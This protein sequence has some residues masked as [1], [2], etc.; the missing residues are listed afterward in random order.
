MN[1]PRFIQIHSL[2]SYPAV[3]LNRDDSG[4]AKQMKFGGANRTRISSQSIKHSH[5][6]A[7]DRYA[8]HNIP[9]AEAAI[10]S[11]H[12]VDRQVML[13][14][15]ELEGVSQEV[16]D[17]VA[18][19]F[20]AG[21]YGDRATDSQQGGGQALLLGLPEVRYLQQEASRICR[22]FPQDPEQAAQEA[23]LVFGPRKEKINNFRAFRDTCALPGGL[24]G[25]M[26]GRMVTS[27]PL[28]NIHASICVAHSLT[29]HLRETESDYFSVVD[30][31]LRTGA[32]LLGETELTSGLFYGYQVV[33][34]PNLV[35]NT[36]GVHPDEWLDVDRSM[37]ANLVHNL[38][39]LIATVTPGAKQGSTACFTRARLVLLEAGET[40]PFTLANA[41]RNPV[42]PQMEPTMEA[43]RKEMEAQDRNYGMENLRA[44]MSME[45]FDLP[46]TNRISLP[47]LATW[48][49]NLILNGRP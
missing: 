49:E 24:E 21:L 13:P 33:N 39:W 45:E 16:L 10:R 17:T 26:Y 4:M 42:A 3:L 5:R 32:A 47:D 19:R 15:R 28:A 48:G 35:S 36:M 43:L 44:A 41:F 31:L 23:D 11:R 12:T 8:I 2:H 1:L 30:D 40:Q 7:Q 18:D 9:G 14:A 37:A 38:I 34:V 27:D 20:T 29:T 46:H 22:D 25:A 6:H